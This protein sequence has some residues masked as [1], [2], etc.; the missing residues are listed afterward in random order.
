MRHFIWDYTPLIRFESE[1]GAVLENA[2]NLSIEVANEAMGHKG[3]AI[4]VQWDV[5]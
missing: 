3:G 4:V 2:G 1:G 5:V